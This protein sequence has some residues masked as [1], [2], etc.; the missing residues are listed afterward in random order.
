M[1]L[2]FSMFLECGGAAPGVPAGAHAH[3]ERSAVG[4][5]GARGG[6]VLERSLGALRTLGISGV[7][8]GAH[9]MKKHLSENHLVQGAHVSALVVLGALGVGGLS[10]RCTW[11]ARRSTWCSRCSWST[12]HHSVYLLEEPR[13][14]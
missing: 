14:T 4:A 13:C 2:E 11:S 12:K 10:A 5:L 8:V 6:G 9:G 3:L 7:F 1:W